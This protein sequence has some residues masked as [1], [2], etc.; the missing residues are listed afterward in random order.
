MGARTT[1][2]PQGAHEDSSLQ[3]RAADVVALVAVPLGDGPSRHHLP[4]VRD[5][6]RLVVAPVVDARL[7]VHA[8]PVRAVNGEEQAEHARVVVGE[9]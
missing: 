1:G 8:D 3:G 4:A 6:V 9:P 2:Q 7:H 5:C